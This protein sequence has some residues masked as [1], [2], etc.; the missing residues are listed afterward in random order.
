[1]VRGAQ[2]HKWHRRA[3]HF[4]IFP[5]LLKLVVLL[6][7]TLSLSPPSPLSPVPNDILPHLPGPTSSCGSR[8]SSL[9]GRAHHQQHDG[10]RVWVCLGMLGRRLVSPGLLHA[11]RQ[12]SPPS[13]I[14]KCLSFLPF[15]PHH[16]RVSLVSSLSQVS[17]FSSTS[18]VKL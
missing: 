7:L 17:L 6:F 3:T 13:I 12:G 9:I 2:G 5:P 10:A 4:L 1:M 16:Q 8:R 11:S 15:F 14:V 18:S